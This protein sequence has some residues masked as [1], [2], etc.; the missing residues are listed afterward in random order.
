M[1]YLN[2]SVRVKNILINLSGLSKSIVF[3]FLILSLSLSC[4]RNIKKDAETF[5]RQNTDIS[6]DEILIGDNLNFWGL[7]SPQA[8]IFILNAKANFLKGFAVKALKFKERDKSQDELET[9][10]S[11]DSIYQLEVYEVS[12]TNPKLDSKSPEICDYISNNFNRATLIAKVQNIPLRVKE[13]EWIWINTK[14]DSNALIFVRLGVADPFSFISNK[15][16]DAIWINA[17]RSYKSWE[18]YLPTEK[19][20]IISWGCQEAVFMDNRVI[21]ATFYNPDIVFNYY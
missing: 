13:R 9:S 3:S 8:G 21:E 4:T 16:I 10:I 15:S 14:V 20:A 7:D 5:E 19:K 11:T 1:Y 18:E 2:H 6:T 12:K 17:K